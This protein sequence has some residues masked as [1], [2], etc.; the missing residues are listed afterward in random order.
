MFGESDRS[1]LYDLQ[2]KIEPCA[3]HN[4]FPMHCTI[5]PRLA[6]AHLFLLTKLY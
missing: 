5:F 6:W 1:Y 2:H 3:M 4:M